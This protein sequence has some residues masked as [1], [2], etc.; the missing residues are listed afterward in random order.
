MSKA[1][2]VKDGIIIGETIASSSH[3]LEDGTYVIKPLSEDE[4]E[5]L[6][7]QSD[8]NK[9]I[10]DA[11]DKLREYHKACIEQKATATKSP[12]A[13]NELKETIESIDTDIRNIASRQI[14][15]E[16]Q[17]ANVLNRISKAD[18]DWKI[19]A[20][21]KKLAKDIQNPENFNDDIN[22]PIKNVR[23]NKA[24]IVFTSNG[25]VKILCN[26]DDNDGSRSALQRLI[27]GALRDSGA[28][29]ATGFCHDDDNTS[30]SSK[31]SPCNNEFSK[32]YFF[33]IPCKS[34]V[35]LLT[36]SNFYIIIK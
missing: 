7:R 21:I 23:G 17:A 8:L 32:L 4:K 15:I 22:I 30:Y 24:L 11:K 18:N 16:N 9:K 10:R 1:Y 27:V 29:N 26:F 33:T 20:D 31:I 36:Y 14:A 3:A 13:A 2:I 6:L 19:E 34:L 12:D 35:S 5:R 25:I 28:K